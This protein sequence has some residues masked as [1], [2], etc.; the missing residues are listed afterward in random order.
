MT[1]NNKQKQQTRIQ[2]IETKYQIIEPHLNEKTRRLWAAA[3]ASSLGYGGVS[4]VAAATH[5]ARSTIHDGLHDLTCDPLDQESIRKDGGGRKPLTATDPLLA[6]DL[7]KLIAPKTRG[8]PMTP[9]RWVSKSTTNIANQLRETGHAIGRSTVGT[10][11]KEA[12]YSLQSNRKTSEGKDHPDRDAQFQ[13]I[14]DDVMAAQAANQP[15]ISVDTKKKENIGNYK[16][17]GKRYEPK[18]TPTEVNMHDFPN[19]ELGKVA[20][21]GVYDVSANEGWVSVGIDHDTAEFAANGIRTWW[22]NLGKDRYP[23]ATELYIT[24]DSGGSNSSRS[25]LWK[26][27]LQTLADELHLTIH[28]RHY[29]PGTS[30]WNKIEHKLFCFI[31]GNWKGEPLVDRATVISLIGATTN[32]TGLKVYASLDENSYPTGKKVSDK[33]LAEVNITREDFHG[34]W[35]YAIA[36]RDYKL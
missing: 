22:Y 12:H 13:R 21:Y 9:L 31:T 33:E 15:V 20:P 32:K 2:I 26:V 6:A 8:D 16:N 30:K 34:E 11:L 35:N 3:E 25:R 19:K 29:P 10:L 27:A 24:S 1:E 5:I 23:D 4:T 36:P 17:G 14:H 7:D 18:G 28:V